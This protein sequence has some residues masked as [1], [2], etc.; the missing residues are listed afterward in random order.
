ME[1]LF[2]N[3]T[4]FVSKERILLRRNRMNHKLSV[5]II[6]GLMLPFFSVVQASLTDGL[7]GYWRL[8]EGSGIVAVDSV[9]GNDGTLYNFS[10]TGNSGWTSGRFGGGL[11]FDDI[12]DYVSTLLMPPP[13]N[14]P[15][16]IALWAKTPISGGHAMSAAAYGGGAGDYGTSFR[17]QFNFLYGGVSFYEGVSADV[18]GGVVTYSAKIS[19]DEWH[20]YAWVVPIGAATVKDVEVYMDGVRL[21]QIAFSWNDIMAIDTVPISPFE[22]GRYFDDGGYY[23]LGVLDEVRVYDRALSDSEIAALYIGGGNQ[24]PVAS[25]KSLN[26]VELGD[27]DEETFDGGHMVGGVIRFDPTES[28]DPDGEIIRYD[29]DFDNGEQFTSTEPQKHDVVFEEPRIYA[30]TLTVTDNDGLTNTFAETLDLSLKEGDLI[31]LRSAGYTTLFDLVGNVYTH[32]GMYVGGQEMIES[33]ISANARSNGRT[34]VVRTPLSGWS[35][36][37]EETYATLVRVETADDEIRQ[38]A[39][40]FVQSKVGQKYDLNVWQKNADKPGYYCSELIWAA[41][42]KA[43]KK[44]RGPKGIID[45]GNT[46]K[47][48]GVWPD[49]I[50]YDTVNIP[51]INGRIGYHHEHYPPPFSSP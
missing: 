48:G 31:F 1:S 29:W 43:S 33:I 8:D 27:P 9:G 40:E 4:Y 7:I 19:D 35:Y 41:Y 36:R 21:T 15:R 3:Q 38:K 34:G 28:Y 44:V 18:S 23:F 45:L 11:A 6:A 14:E 51:E 16:T 26:V 47:K 20:C 22:I 25:F 37:W 17:S 5:L 13:G 24:P 39:V 49:D 12:D 32:V 10:F 46:G 30:I 42:Y 2:D 50:I